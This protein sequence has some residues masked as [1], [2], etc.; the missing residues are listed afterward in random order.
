MAIIPKITGQ[1]D[2]PSLFMGEH[3]VQ[4]LYK[5]PLICVCTEK[6]KIFSLKISPTETFNITGQLKGST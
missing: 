2:Q 3:D 6:F 4:Q 1:S 5:G